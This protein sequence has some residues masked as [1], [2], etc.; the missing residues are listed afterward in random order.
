MTKREKIEL[1]IAA[2]ETELESIDRLGE[3]RAR[4]HL[5]P[6]RASQ[7]ALAAELES[8]RE[9]LADMPDVEGEGEGDKGGG[10][11]AGGRRPRRSK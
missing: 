6:L 8:L 1:R 9:Q 5:E 2:I 10:K 3:R 11:P 4:K 7:E